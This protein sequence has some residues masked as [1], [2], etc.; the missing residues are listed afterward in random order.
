MHGRVKVKTSEQIQRE[1]KEKEKKRINAF[2]ELSDK[3][4]HFNKNKIYNEE[5]LKI[6]KQTIEMNT[7]FYTVWNYRRRALESF[8][9]TKTEEEMIEHY[10]QEMELTTG[11]VQLNAKSY[12]IWQHR[13]WAGLK[14]GPD[15]WDWAKELGLCTRFLKLDSR[16]FHCWSYR[17]FVD[18]LG[19]ISVKQEFDYTTKL[20]EDNFSNY[21]AWHQRSLLF[22]ILHPP[23]HDDSKK[24]LINELDWIWRAMYTLP[25]DQSAWIYH[26]WLIGQVK[27]Q[28][29]PA[30]KDEIL[31]AELTRAEELLQEEANSKWPMLATVILMREIDSCGYQQQ[32][33]ENCSTLAQVDSDHVEYYREL[34]AK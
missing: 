29:N 33:K 23:G 15:R 24:A 5:G 4:M 18:K 30:F 22:P 1:N 26:R 16:N 8:S 6:A 17:R 2:C 12:W 7:E 10:K 21:S 34:I 31:R 11:A 14:L 9:E 32:I 27:Q 28:D 19:G 20:I 25:D 3:F 13:K